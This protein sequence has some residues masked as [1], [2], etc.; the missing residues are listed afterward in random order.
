MKYIVLSDIPSCLSEYV[1]DVGYITRISSLTFTKNG[2]A[3]GVFDGMSS[4]S[5][6]LTQEP[7]QLLSAGRHIS[8]DSNVIN[9]TL[10]IFGAG[11]VRVAEGPCGNRVIISA[12]IPKKVS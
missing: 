7:Q 12:S 4:L 11:D 10:S 3:V 6:D 8:I 2:E 5:V 1:N 9:S